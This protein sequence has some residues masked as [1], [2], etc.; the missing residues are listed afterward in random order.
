MQPSRPAAAAG[1][2][3]CQSE[4]IR[5]PVPTAVRRRRKGGPAAGSGP[6]RWAR[7]CAACARAPARGHANAC[8]GAHVDF[9]GPGGSL[10][11]TWTVAE[12]DSDNS[13]PLLFFIKGLHSARV[14]RELAGASKAWRRGVGPG[15]RAGPPGRRRWSSGRAVRGRCVNPL[16]RLLALAPVLGSLTPRHRARRCGYWMDHVLAIPGPGPAESLRDP[17]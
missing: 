3:L 17:C 16:H 4:S 5:V 11:G 2:V 15:H 1:G 14:G 9:P 13:V 12:S 6:W 8:A 10:I 7:T